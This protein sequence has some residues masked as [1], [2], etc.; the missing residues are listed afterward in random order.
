M[1]FISEIISM[2]QRGSTRTVGGVTHYVDACHC[3]RS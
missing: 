2:G 3:H 1:I